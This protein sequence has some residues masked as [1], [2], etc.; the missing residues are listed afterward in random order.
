MAETKKP[1]TKKAT[2]KVE[3]SVEEQLVT[4]RKDL[5]AARK[6]HA[7]GELVNPRI[8]KKYRKD[9]ARLLTKRNAKK[10]EK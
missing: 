3:Q 7:S 6:S 4:A 2:P 9:I 10:G 8:L 5:W 1:A